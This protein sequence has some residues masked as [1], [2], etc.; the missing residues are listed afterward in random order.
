[1]NKTRTSQTLAMI[2]LG[3]VLLAGCSG[4][5]SDADASASAGAETATS[6]VPEASGQPQAGGQGDFQPSGVS[7]EVAYVSDGTAQVQDGDSQTAVR[8]TDDT[9]VTTEVEIAL[10]D[11]EEGQCVVVVLG[12]DDT[13]TSVSVSDADDDGTCAAGFGGGGGQMPEG[14]EMPSDGEVPSDMPTAMPEGME[15]P[16]DGEMPEREMPEG[17]FGGSFVTGAVTAIGD[18][19]LSVE[20]SEGETTDVTLADDAT[21]TGTEATDSDAIEVGMCMTAQ[22]ESDSSGG[23]DATTIALSEATDE[24]CT[25]GFGGMRGGMGGGMGGPGGAGD[26]LDSLDSAG[27]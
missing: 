23:Y 18:G 27:E 11:I 5:D 25:S 2:G 22:G 13:A 6:A 7:G 24:G 9:E 1:M 21:V 26:E 17:G 10:A 14:M 16:S 19:T 20:D 12:D 3:A 4:G 15:A 8:F